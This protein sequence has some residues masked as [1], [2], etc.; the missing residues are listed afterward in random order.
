MKRS[1]QRRQGSCGEQEREGAGD[2]ARFVT[3][4]V[5]AFAA[6]AGAVFLVGVEAGLSKPWF[7][8]VGAVPALIVSYVLPAAP[9]AV[10]ACVLASHGALAVT[11]RASASG[12][13]ALTGG[14]M[15]IAVVLGEAG[16][17]V[18]AERG[19]FGQRPLV[20]SGTKEMPPVRTRLRLPSA[21]ISISPSMT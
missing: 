13:V 10:V 5:A 12:L 2:A 11:A 16:G 3:W 9:S 15:L 6:L 20:D 17:R 1:L 7:L 18:P 8:A 14:L 21:W 19:L 4:P